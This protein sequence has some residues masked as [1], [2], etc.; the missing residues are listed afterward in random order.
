MLFSVS[1][2]VSPSV[3]LRL[4]APLDRSARELPSSHFNGKLMV[5]SGVSALVDFGGLLPAA[6]LEAD[7]LERQALFQIVGLLYISPRAALERGSR[8]AWQDLISGLRSTNRPARPLWA[9]TENRSF[10]STRRVTE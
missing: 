1:I 5:P 4:V 9:L 7:G 2:A 6:R 3:E 8:A 10:Q